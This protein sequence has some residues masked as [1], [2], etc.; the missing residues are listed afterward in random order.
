M[1]EYKIVTDKTGLLIIDMTNAFLAQGAPV[2]VPNGTGIIPGLKKLM[3]LAR[4]KGIRIIYTTQSY[5]KDGA[6]LGI[7]PLFHPGMEKRNEL[8][9]GSTDVEFYKD[10]VPEA[11]DTI[12][13][14]PRFSAFIGTELELILRSQGIDTLI[15]GGVLTNVCCESTAREARMRDFKVIFLSDGTATRDIPDTGWGKVPAAE[16]QRY[17][18][19]AIACYF[20]QVCSIE[21]VM[22]QISISGN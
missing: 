12:I 6:D 14:K 7:D 5:H 2:M 10:I 22:K 13:V 19:A 15:I 21:Q 8:R 3:G 4:S 17:T 18:L 11:S 9:E 16:M 1:P 20:G